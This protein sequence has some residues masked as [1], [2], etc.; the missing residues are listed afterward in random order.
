MFFFAFGGAWLALG[1]REAMASPTAAYVVIAVLTLTFF[2]L[3]RRGV[4]LLDLKRREIEDAAHQPWERVSVHRP[5][6]ISRRKL[7]VYLH[8]LLPA[9]PPEPPV[10]RG[11][12]VILESSLMTRFR[13]KPSTRFGTMPSDRGTQ[14]PSSMRA[15]RLAL[16]CA[17]ALMVVGCQPEPKNFKLT[18]NF[19]DYREEFENLRAMIVHD[20]GLHRVDANWTD[21]AY[22]ISVGV[23]PERIAGYRALFRKLGMSRGVYSHPGKIDLIAHAESISLRDHRRDTLG[24]H[25]LHWSLFLTLRCKRYVTL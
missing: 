15:T 12:D 13:C 14:N 22:P 3:A 9:V 6:W 19:Q 2:L 24:L 18:K 4:M 8:G 11:Y 7:Q 23:T 5:E 10:H 25:L 21:L 17:F 20:G 1:S 16:T